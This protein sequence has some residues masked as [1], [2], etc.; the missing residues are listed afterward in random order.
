MDLREK[1]A[2]IQH[3]IWS[4]WMHYLFSVSIE[5]DNGHFFIQPYHADRWHRQMNTPYDDLSEDEKES[6]RHQADKLKPMLI[7]HI[8][9]C[10]MEAIKSYYRKVCERAEEKMEQTHKLEGSH[11]AAM[12]EVLKEFE[13]YW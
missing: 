2:S 7:A 12:Q 3:E 5:D 8:R 1:I 4:H 10:E 11:Y 9:K 13:R 6:D